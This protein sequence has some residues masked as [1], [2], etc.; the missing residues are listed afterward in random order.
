M[1]KKGDV[2][3]LPRNIVALILAILGIVAIIAAVA[4]ILLGYFGN[5]SLEKAGANLNYI[6]DEIRD[7]KP[8]E[9][10]MITITNPINWWLVYFDENI[11]TNSAGFAK[12]PTF[13][14]KK[15]LCVCKDTKCDAKACSEIDKSVTKAGNPVLIKIK[16]MDVNV[17]NNANYYD[18]N[19]L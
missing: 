18:F 2:E 5:V 19:V 8:G 16:I 6:V 3:L 15:T 1:N 4:V 9:S 11:N 13:L 17:T 12:P 14:N 7:I 10:K